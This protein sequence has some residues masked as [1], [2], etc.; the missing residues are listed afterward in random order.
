MTLSSAGRFT[1]GLAVPPFTRADVERIAR[2]LAE[3]R[4]VSRNGNGRKTFCP[5]CETENRRR[6]PRPTL[7]ITAR[8]GKPL[9]YCHRCKRPG[10]E[11]IRR[12]VQ[13]GM[14]HDSF[15]LSSRVLARID[16]VRGAAARTDWKGVG[17]TNALKALGALCEIGQRCF[18]GVI[19][20][21]ER[22]VA[23]LTDISAPTAGK[24]LK[25][26]ARRGWLEQ[27]ERARGRNAATW[28]LRIPSSAPGIE[29][30]HSGRAE[31]ASDRVKHFD[32]C[33]TGGRVAP[34]R[35]AA[36]FR[37]DLFRSSKGGLGPV[38]GRVYAILV[39]PM[40]SKEIAGTLGLKYQRNAMLHVEVLVRE[41]LVRRLPDSRYQRT[42]ADLD[43]IADRRGV[44]GAGERQRER[45]HEDR[46]R[47]RRWCDSLD[48]YQKTG[49]VVA[50]DTGVL[51]E[52]LP[53][54]GQRP[55]MGAF[56]L[57]V[58]SYGLSEIRESSGGGLSPNSGSTNGRLTSTVA[59]TRKGRANGSDVERSR[60]RS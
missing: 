27:V 49:E 41:G 7:S 8:N 44:L 22:E 40:P 39:S 26:L 4:R 36:P 29:L 48:H 55:K 11:I 32:P 28:R 31:K 37:H 54:P 14:L 60:A 47:W 43:E 15:Q 34:S 10:I 25:R 1:E 58:S 56:R 23:D 52:R 59:T 16:E 33:S 5:F 3:G 24:A 2:Q 50:P 42:A 57:V 12:L 21:S 46:Q 35:P 6:R 45:H 18:K 38:K 20:A 17:A 9:F 19:A 30:S 13:R 51:L 53:I